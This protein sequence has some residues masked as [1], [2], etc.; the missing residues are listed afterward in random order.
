MSKT[1]FVTEY[2]WSLDP[3][4]PHLG[5][6]YYGIGTPLAGG[7]VTTAF[8][9]PKKDGIQLG[10]L[11]VGELG[12]MGSGHPAGFNVALCDGS[13]RLQPYDIDIMLHRRFANR[14]D[15]ASR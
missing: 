8:H 12:R 6:N 9:K 5:E 4:N 7:Y 10:T 1:Y 14:K 11:P 2:R 13:V 15:G 3:D